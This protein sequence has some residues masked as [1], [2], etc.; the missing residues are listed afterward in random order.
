MAIG[1]YVGTFGPKQKERNTGLVET[2]TGHEDVATVTIGFTKERG[3]KCTK[4][5]TLTANEAMTLALHMIHQAQAVN[6]DQG[7]G[8]A[9]TV[10][11][12]INRKPLL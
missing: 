5:L 2:W 1:F 8:C 7:N 12:D 9:P 10:A 6:D 11:W 3:K 4:L